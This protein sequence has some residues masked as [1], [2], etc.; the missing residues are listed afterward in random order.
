MIKLFTISLTFKIAI[1]LAILFAVNSNSK[2]KKQKTDFKN[3]FFEP[4]DEEVNHTAREE[5]SKI[6]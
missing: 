5:M 4:R 3:S 6:T 2:K 1:L